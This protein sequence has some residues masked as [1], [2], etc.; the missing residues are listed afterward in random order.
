MTITG[1]CVRTHPR[2]L[3]GILIVEAYS[4]TRIHQ[5]RKQA[6]RGTGVDPIAVPTRPPLAPRYSSSS[7]VFGS[8]QGSPGSAYDSHS[9]SQSRRESDAMSPIDGGGI[10]RTMSGA[11]ISSDYGTNGSYGANNEPSYGTNGG[12]GFSHT[13]RGPPTYYGRP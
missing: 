8:M 3:L 11:S 4:G 10:S 1:I 12:Y 2:I 5:N 9:R 6:C 7:S 13:T